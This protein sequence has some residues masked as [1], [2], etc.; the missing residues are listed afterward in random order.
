MYAVLACC[1]EGISMLFSESLSELALLAKY[2]Y[3]E[4]NCFLF[5]ALTY[6]YYSA[7]AFEIRVNDRGCESFDVLVFLLKFFI[8]KEQICIHE[9]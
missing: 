5:V 1:M 2:T 3:K 9:E 7:T 8:S 4:F 6:N